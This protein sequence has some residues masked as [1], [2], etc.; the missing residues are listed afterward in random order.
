MATKKVSE[1]V[2]LTT[3]AVGDLL[4]VIDISEALDVDK[5]KKITM[6]NLGN[7]LPSL[8]GL[9]NVGF[10][11]VY[12]AGNSGAATTIDWATNGNLQKVTLT[13][14]CTFTF[15]APSKPG[16]QRLIV[17]GNGTDYLCTWPA[18]VIWVGLIGEP[19]WNGDAG[20]KNVASFLYDG[21]D[22]IGSGA[23]DNN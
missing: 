17:I 18:T 9:K 8:L 23:E 5:A 6:T 4:Y 10:D 1:L 16:G 15:T 7:V 3:P 2:A 19:L 22:Y 11:A 13:A 20:N 12:D 14:N 21:T